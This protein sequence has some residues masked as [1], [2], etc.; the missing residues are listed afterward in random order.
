MNEDGENLENTEWLTKTVEY[1]NQILE[2]GG[3]KTDDKL[4][5]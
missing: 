2:F 1:T 5:I 3:E 4:T